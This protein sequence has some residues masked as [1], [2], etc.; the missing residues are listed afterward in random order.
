[1][2]IIT[3]VE[4]TTSNKLLKPKHGLSLYIEANNK[5]ILLCGNGQKEY[6]TGYL[7]R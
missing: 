4:N 7:M 5:K 3:L 1:M 6:F 2:K